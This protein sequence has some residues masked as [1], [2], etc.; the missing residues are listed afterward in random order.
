MNLLTAKNIGKK[1]TFPS[2][3]FYYTKP[4]SF[5]LLPK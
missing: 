1:V 2:F 5:P 4:A 3:F